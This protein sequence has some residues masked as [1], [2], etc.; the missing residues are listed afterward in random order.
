MNYGN[1]RREG[2]CLIR[3]QLRGWNEVRL[4]NWCCDVLWDMVETF[5]RG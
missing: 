5:V 1:V 3:K 2:M 4:S